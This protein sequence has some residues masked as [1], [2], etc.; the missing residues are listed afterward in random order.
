MRLTRRLKATSDS[1]RC[2][3]EYVRETSPQLL[4]VI[5]IAC[6]DFPT[7]CSHSPMLKHLSSCSPSDLL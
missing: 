7:R 3:A 5:G 6:M 1:Y 2:L 4:S